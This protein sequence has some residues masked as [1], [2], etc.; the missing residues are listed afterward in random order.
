MARLVVLM[1]AAIAM[2][3]VLFAAPTNAAAAKADEAPITDEMQWEQAPEGEWALAELDSEADAEAEAEADSEADADA[4]DDPPVQ[5]SGEGCSSFAEVDSA[6]DV[7]AEADA[8]A[9][10][11]LDAEVDAEM[12]AE[13]D[14]EAEA[15]AESLSA[16]DIAN[17][18]CGDYAGA[19]I[20][21]RKNN[22]GQSVNVVAIK[23]EHLTNPSQYGKS[24]TQA[25]NA[26]LTTTAC[27][28]SKLR[29]A[30]K[31]AGHTITINSGFRS[32]ARQQYFWNCYQ[33]KVQKKKNCCNNGNLAARPGRSNHGTGIALDLQLTTG[34]Y[35]WMRTNAEKNGFVRT[36]SSERWHWEYRPGKKQSSFFRI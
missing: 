19:A 9:D 32:L 13:L 21:T 12:D 7:D 14:A 5:P 8:D 30:A 2:L 23:K 25:D 6:A 11:D 24:E 33:C 34:A 16:V 4:A 15:E 3:A 35:N 1:L 18:L 26:M 17:G 28:Y 36:V 27:G 22:A 10:V 31:A 29:A 20:S